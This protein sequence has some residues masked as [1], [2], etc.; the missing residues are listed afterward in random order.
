MSW[1][2][3]HQLKSFKGN[4][5]RE[6]PI[7]DRPCASTTALT[8]RVASKRALSSPCQVTLR[9]VSTLGMDSQGSRDQFWLLNWRLCSY[10]IYIYIMVQNGCRKPSQYVSKA[11]ARYL[12]LFPYEAENESFSFAGWKSSRST[13]S[14]SHG[15]PTGEH[16]PFEFCPG[17]TA[18]DFSSASVIHVLA[19]EIDMYSRSSFR[20]L[21]VQ[22][23]RIL[24]PP[25]RERNRK[26]VQTAVTYPRT[27]PGR[28]NL[29]CNQEYV[30][31]AA[32]RTRHRVCGT[33]F[34]HA[35]RM[36]SHE[37]YACTAHAFTRTRIWCAVLLQIPP[38][39]PPLKGVNSRQKTG[40]KL[41]RFSK[42]NIRFGSGRTGSKI[43]SK[44]RLTHNR[45]LRL[46]NRNTIVHTIACPSLLL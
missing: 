44:F 15:P 26:H 7:S 18:R 11:R 41:E 5:V 22:V 37:M 40:K 3:S 45:K 34:R 4:D 12:L 23:T 14:L 19:W 17:F 2:S 10:W 30:R 36:R 8:K 29:S 13:M 28:N 46:A 35:L 43:V 24:P 20:S 6:G 33:N 9:F 21:H 16:L 27:D 39:P 38:P 31:G 32:A 1:L 42:P 25:T